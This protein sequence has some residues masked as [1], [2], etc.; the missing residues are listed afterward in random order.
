MLSL[1]IK[2]KNY[3]EDKMISKLRLVGYDN[4]EDIVYITGAILNSPM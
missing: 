1:E 4:N 2:Y 3:D